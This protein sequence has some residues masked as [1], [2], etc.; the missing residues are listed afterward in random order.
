MKI[1]RER[2]EVANFP[3][4]WKHPI[5]PIGAEDRGDDYDLLETIQDQPVSSSAPNQ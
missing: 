2:I 3:S 5:Q 1:L 4:G